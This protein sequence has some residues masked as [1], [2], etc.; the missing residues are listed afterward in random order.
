MLASYLL[1][2]DNVFEEFII[3][4]NFSLFQDLNDMPE[5]LLMFWPFVLQQYY[6]LSQHLITG[7][8]VTA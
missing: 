5:G 7:F 8:L 2:T 1:D 4:E 6:Q 3:T